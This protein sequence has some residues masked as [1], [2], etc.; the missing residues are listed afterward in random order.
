[1]KNSQSIFQTI[2][3]QRNK[4]TMLAS[5]NKQNLS[6][7][8]RNGQRITILN[9]SNAAGFICYR[10]VCTPMC[11]KR[12]AKLA[13]HRAQK[14]AW[15]T[16][17]LFTQWFKDNFVVEVRRHLPHQNIPPHTKLVLLLDNCAAHTRLKLN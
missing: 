16:A 1:M 7:T 17:F 11:F 5:Q 3:L 6:G 15:M 2:T 8:K 10:Q 13:C 4:Y 9:C 14:N 12:R